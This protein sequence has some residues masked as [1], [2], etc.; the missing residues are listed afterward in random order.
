MHDMEIWNNFIEEDVMPQRKQQIKS[1]H[2]Y[3]V[4][5]KEQILAQFV[6][7]FDRFYQNVQLFC[8]M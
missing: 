7:L 1:L 8:R 4:R 2:N 5:H 3:Y 6:P